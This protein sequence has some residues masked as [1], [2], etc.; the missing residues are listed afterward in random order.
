MAV[1]VKLGYSLSNYY[2]LD[3]SDNKFG[4]FS[5]AGI[6]T[7]PLGSTTKFGCVE[8]PRRRGVP[9]ARRH[10]EVLQR[11]RRLPGDWV[12]RDWVFL[13]TRCVV[14]DLVFVSVSILFFV[15]S[16]GYVAACD[17]LMK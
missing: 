4:F 17:R 2:E 15:V 16:I 8:P 7:V 10:H 6:V 1:P 13:L 12:H 9:D 5:I 3:G 11:R 14:L